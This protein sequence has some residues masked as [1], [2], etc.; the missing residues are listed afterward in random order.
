GRAEAARTARGER[1]PGTAYI[2]RGLQRCQHLSR[3]VCTEFLRATRA[4]LCAASWG[5]R[6]RLSRAVPESSSC[7][8][9]LPRMQAPGWCA[10]L[11]PYSCDL[12]AQWGFARRLGANRASCAC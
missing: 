10:V 7:R 12:L 9:A 2:V 4:V 8:G 11:R 6:P 1:R 5:G 3:V